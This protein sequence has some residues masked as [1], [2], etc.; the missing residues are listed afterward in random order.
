MQQLNAHVQSQI[1]L[2]KFESLLGLTPIMANEGQIDKYPSNVVR[3]RQTSNSIVGMGV[4]HWL[5]G[6]KQT[7]Q[8]QNTMFMFEKFVANNDVNRF[9]IYAF[10]GLML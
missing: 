6:V 5:A 8:R 4:Y 2:A 9:S 10:M 1:G 7:W 3:H